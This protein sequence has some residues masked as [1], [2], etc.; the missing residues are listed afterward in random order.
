MGAELR[1]E[2]FGASSAQNWVCVYLR[3]EFFHILR[4]AEGLRR[5]K[6][7]GFTGRVVFQRGRVSR[8]VRPA[9]LG[10]RTGAT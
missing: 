2:S 4:S 3:N 8:Q 10:N 5:R 7:A 6:A 1:T 9:G